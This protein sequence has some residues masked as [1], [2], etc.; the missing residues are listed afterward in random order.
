ML[1]NINAYFKM[2]LTNKIN[3]AILCVKKKLLVYSKIH[4][5]DMGLIMRDNEVGCLCAVVFY[6]FI[7]NAVFTG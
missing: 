3:G 6:L 5:P 1:T 4:S 7:N 2:R